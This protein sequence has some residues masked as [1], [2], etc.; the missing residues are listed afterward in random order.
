MILNNYL[1]C[2][3]WPFTPVLS[4]N[5]LLLIFYFLIRSPVRL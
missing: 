5:N 1:L 2:E 3:T 4:W